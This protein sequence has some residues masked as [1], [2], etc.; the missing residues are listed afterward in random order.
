MGTSA[1]ILWHWGVRNTCLSLIWKLLGVEGRCNDSNVQFRATEMS[2]DLLRNFAATLV[3]KQ[4]T[5]LQW[6]TRLCLPY[7]SKRVII[8]SA[9]LWQVINPIILVLILV[10]LR[11]KST[12]I[13]LLQTRSPSTKLFR[14]ELGWNM[15][16]VPTKGIPWMRWNTWSHVGDYLKF[17]FF[18][19]VG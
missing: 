16:L 3:W 6:C 8:M 17:F 12:L 7:L 14:S 2:S 1:G 19:F 18:R 15:A 11:S 13:D 9:L 4:L 10:L 5:P